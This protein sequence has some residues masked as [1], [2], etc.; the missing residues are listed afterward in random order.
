MLSRVN[1]QAVLLCFSCVL[2]ACKSD[3]GASARLPTM[4]TTICDATRKP[5]PPGGQRIVLRAEF[6]SDR[7]ERSFLQD[8]RCPRITVV[9]RDAP[10]VVKD[11]SYEEFS[12]ILNAHPLQVGLIMVHVEVYGTLK[13]DGRGYRM[14][15]IRYIES[16]AK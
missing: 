11:S 13:R 2:W 5:M 1:I 12:R 14:D 9:P 10:D 6:I 4:A 8:N 16:T 7:L 3:A 15:I